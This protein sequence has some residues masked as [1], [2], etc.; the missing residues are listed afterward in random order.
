MS[1][2]AV[3]SQR[4][5]CMIKSF[6]KNN[7]P[8]LFRL[9]KKVKGDDPLF[10]MGLPK[11]EPDDYKAPILNREEGN[12]LVYD[13]LNK[14][15]PFLICR[16]GSAELTVILNYLFIK[17]N[18]IKDWDL[19]KINQGLFRKNA[20]FPATEK[21]LERFAELYLSCLPSI[22]AL[23]VWYNY[24]EQVL[25]KK[26]FPS[27]TLFPI[28]SLEPFRFTKAWSSALAGKKVLVVLPFET[29]VKK[30]YEKRH[31]LFA[32]EDVLPECELIVYKPFNSYTDLPD[33][34][35]D[36]F[37]Y[38]EKMKQEIA[39]IEFDIALIA[40][41]PFG[42]PLAAAIKES[43]RKAIHVGGALQLLFGI[44]G[45]RWE[46]RPEFSVFMNEHWVKPSEN[47]TPDISTKKAI[48]NNSYW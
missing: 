41:G 6:L 32:T 21:T 40:A 13:L 12:Q 29:S 20:V 9:L 17:E 5:S 33:E 27:A 48:D 7:F 14:P 37:F 23:A 28:E 18:K 42:L 31:L 24:G 25:H 34:G 38:L 10:L 36:W 3:F 43:G 44:K 39:A 30:Q 16:L 26:Y 45:N 11:I 4:N 22:D 19:H 2:T 46:E 8:V 47:E 15:D 1:N 35:C